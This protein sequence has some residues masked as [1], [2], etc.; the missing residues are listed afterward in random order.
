MDASGSIANF[1]MMQAFVQKIISNIPLESDSN[2]RVRI[3]VVDA[4]YTTVLT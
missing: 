3:I 2:N 4:T 1:R